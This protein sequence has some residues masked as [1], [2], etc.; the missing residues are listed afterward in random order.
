MR[1][2][3]F[4]KSRIAAMDRFQDGER[5]RPAFGARTGGRPVPARGRYDRQQVVGG[6]GERGNC[7]PDHKETNA[8]PQITRDAPAQ[9]SQFTCSLR[10]YFAS[11]VSST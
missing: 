5:Y 1:E 2:D 8:T 6:G 3:G 10:I 7:E 11:I 4:V 9:R